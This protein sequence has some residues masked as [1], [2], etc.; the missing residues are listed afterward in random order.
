VPVDPLLR[1]QE[2]VGILALDL[3]RRGLDARLLGRNHVQDGDLEALA[4]GPAD[5]HP[6]EHLGPVLRLGAARAR[7]HGENRV[8]GVVWALQ[9]GLEFEIGES[10]GQLIQLLPQLA[11]E[12]W[13]GRLGDELL[14]GTGIGQPLVE[15]V[16]RVDAGAQGLQ[17]LHDVAGLLLVGPEAGIGLPGLEC[18]QPFAAGIKVKGTSAG[19]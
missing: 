7:V 8:P 4:L 19:R 1:F 12:V 2:A 16:G 15:G 11:F 14:H 9:H 10:D 5:V 3:D 17:L 18:L 13:I 6:D